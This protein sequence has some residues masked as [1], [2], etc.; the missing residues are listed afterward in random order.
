[1][2]SRELFGSSTLL[3]TRLPDRGLRSPRGLGQGVAD[4]VRPRVGGVEWGMT[5]LQ[6]RVACFPV[7]LA[8]ALPGA[9]VAADM[10]R[11]VDANG[12]V[13]YSNVP[14]PAHVKATR[15]ADTE[16]TVSVIPPPERAP[17]ARSADRVAALERRIGQLEDEL[18]QLRRHATQTPGH[19]ANLAPV[20]FAD[21]G[22]TF[23]YPVPVR[24]ARVRA[25][26]PRSRIFHAR[27]E[28][29][30]AGSKPHHPA[31]VPHGV[32]GVFDVSS[33]R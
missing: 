20:S 15:I 3:G 30:G 12:V 14:P 11:W 32:R 10:Y 22:V 17:E 21:P 33:G 31:A 1:M 25:H 27:H 18:A 28:H 29:V 4:R 23:V 7:A 9:G 6:R 26:W 5:A 13:N 8:L 16:P 19:A 24:P 2:L